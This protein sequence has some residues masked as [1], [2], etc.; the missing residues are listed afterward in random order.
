MS[1]S[2]A[3]DNMS[4]GNYMMAGLDIITAGDG[5]GFKM[6]GEAALDMKAIG[7]IEKGVRSELVTKND[8]FIQISKEKLTHVIDRHAWNSK[9]SDTSSFLKGVDPVKLINRAQ[10]TK[11]I[12]QEKTGNLIRVV[13]SSKNIGID[14]VTKK[15]TNI[16][17]VVSRNIGNGI[18]KLITT[19]PG[20]PKN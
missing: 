8:G 17:T 13:E 12:L 9:I 20:K 16:Y 6:A 7:G 14:R 19:F 2:S 11:S 1:L 5:R 4:N 10:N 15:S 18:E 3:N